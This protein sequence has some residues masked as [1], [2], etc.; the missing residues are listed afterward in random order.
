MQ[1]SIRNR[2][3]E[4]ILARFV[5][6]PLGDVAVW[7][8]PCRPAIESGCLAGAGCQRNMAS[9]TCRVQYLNDIDPFSASTNFP[10]PA[11]PPH[12]TFNVN[13]P[14]VNQIAGVHRILKAPHKVMH[15]FTCSKL[16]PSTGLFMLF[17]TV[18][19]VLPND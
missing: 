13:I 12:Y 9:L 4:I 3:L 14:L 10:E 19:F 1:R 7:R 11:R 15:I 2:I 8:Q 6:I 16:P 17:C 18:K 5:G